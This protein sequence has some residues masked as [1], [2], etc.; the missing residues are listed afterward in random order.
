MDTAIYWT[1][2]V[3]KYRGTPHLKSAA[4][5]LHWFQYIGLDIALV[6][7]IVIILFIY[8]IYKCTRLSYGGCLPKST[9]KSKKIQ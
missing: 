9:E 4:T 2:Y 1:E 6:Y 3:I 5:E 7:L 8:S